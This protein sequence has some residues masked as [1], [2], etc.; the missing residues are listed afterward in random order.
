MI[1]F[2]EIALPS[3]ARAGSSGSNGHDPPGSGAVIVLQ[4]T[5]SQPKRVKQDQ[6]VGLRPGLQLRGHKVHI[7]PP[8]MRCI[9][10]RRQG[11]HGHI[12]SQHDFITLASE[13][14][15]FFVQAIQ[16]RSAS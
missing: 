1:V 4:E 5:R 2:I 3:Q 16:I 11:N 15:T 6:I 9:P 14:E 13:K 8:Q 10:N 7:G 12:A